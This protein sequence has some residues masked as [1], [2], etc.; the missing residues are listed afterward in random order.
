MEIDQREVA[1]VQLKDL[2]VEVVVFAGDHVGRFAVGEAAKAD[3][4]KLHA[5]VSVVALEGDRPVIQL[6]VLV[7]I[8][9]DFG[10]ARLDVIDQ[11]DAVDPDPRV[12]G[13]RL[14]AQLE[15]L[16]VV[17]GR[18]VDVAQAVKAAGFFKF[19][20]AVFPGGGWCC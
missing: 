15:P 18:F 16:P 9:Q 19:G 20:V 2:A 11:Q 10:V 6:A 5:P 12:L 3:V 13:A 1:A 4:F 7:R 8:V 17:H 14:E